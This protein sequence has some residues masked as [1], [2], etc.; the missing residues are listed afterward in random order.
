MKDLTSKM[1]QDLLNV[2]SEDISNLRKLYNLSDKSV[3]IIILES[4]P[5]RIKVGLGREDWREL[6]KSEDEVKKYIK[7]KSGI[8]DIQE[9]T[10]NPHGYYRFKKGK[11]E[12]CFYFNGVCF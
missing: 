8:S 11:L 7:E 2:D 1:L 3:E 9:V 6:L 4:R 10:L 5:G 12:G